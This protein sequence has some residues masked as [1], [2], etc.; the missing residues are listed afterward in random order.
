MGTSEVDTTWSRLFKDREG[1]RRVRIL[2]AEKASVSGAPP[3][4]SPK[5]VELIAA[6]IDPIS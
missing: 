2:D 3:A 1:P 6:P 4:A 5:L